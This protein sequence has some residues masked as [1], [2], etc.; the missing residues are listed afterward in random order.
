MR[1]LL[2]EPVDDVDPEAV[3]AGL[4]RPVPRDRPYVLVDMIES[5]DG[6]TAID[7]ASGALGGEGDRMVFRAIRTVPDVILVAART[8]NAEHYRAPVISEATRQARLARGQA[9]TPRLAVITGELSVDLSLGMFTDPGEE[10]PLVIT[11]EAAPVNRRDEVEAVAEV[12]V[13]G[14]DLVDLAGALAIL[15]QRGVGIVLCE[16]G[17]TL[18]G[19]MVGLDLVDEWNVSLS[20]TLAGGESHRIA[21]TAPPAVR[22]LDLTH[23][24]EHDGMLF[25][26]YVRGG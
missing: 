4:V 13:V 5:L 25:L 14:D 6:G 21:N 17:P 3:H 8:A 18:N 26:R 20:P 7:G 11:S 23:V 19:G 16:G 24:L 12:L 10:R 9:P 22:P 1:Q 2:P 15:R